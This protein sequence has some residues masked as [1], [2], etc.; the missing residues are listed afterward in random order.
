MV[1][2]AQGPTKLFAV[3]V[4][5]RQ[6]V[7]VLIKRRA[8]VSDQSLD[9][10]SYDKCPSISHH[11]ADYVTYMYNF[12]KYEYMLPTHYIAMLSIYRNRGIMQF[13]K[14]REISVK[15]GKD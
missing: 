6:K 15:I 3:D 11:F 2:T 13:G 8:A 10:L 5:E 1:K 12:Y 7:A 14:L 4:Y 9:F